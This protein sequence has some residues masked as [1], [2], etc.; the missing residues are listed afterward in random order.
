LTDVVEN[1]CKQGKRKREQLKCKPVFAVKGANLQRMLGGARG[2]LF[3][4]FMSPLASAGSA[5]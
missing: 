2:V 3:Q 5:A 4:D 1:A